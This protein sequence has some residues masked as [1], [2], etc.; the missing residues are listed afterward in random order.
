MI[1]HYDGMKAALFT[2]SCRGLSLPH[3]SDE[4]EDRKHERRQ[5]QEE[6]AGDLEKPSRKA[7]RER[8]MPMLQTLVDACQPMLT[9]PCTHSDRRGDISLRNGEKPRIA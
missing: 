1:E 9:H 3:S 5:R 2:P 4:D 8:S 6:K 7:E